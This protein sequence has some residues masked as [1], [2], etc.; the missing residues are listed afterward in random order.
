M[1]RTV[2]VETE[3]GEIYK[4][5]LDT[6]GR[7][8]GAHKITYRPEEAD[9]AIIDITHNESRFHAENPSLHVLYLFRAGS[10]Q[11]LKDEN[12]GK[13]RFRSYNAVQL[14]RDPGELAFYF[15]LGIGDIPPCMR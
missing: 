2:Y 7:F 9:C 10:R 11:D 15:L 1:P 8:F 6:I 5:I 14:T 3:N 4:S 13:A 12:K